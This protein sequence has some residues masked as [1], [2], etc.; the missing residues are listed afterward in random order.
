MTDT[1]SNQGDLC[2]LSSAEAIISQ[3]DPDSSWPV[4]YWIFC[5]TDLEPNGFHQT[6][7]RLGINAHEYKSD[8]LDRSQIA[9][10]FYYGVEG[11]DAN[12]KEDPDEAVHR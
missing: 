11:D 10:D 5:S 1:V 3:G 6:A 9:R 12:Q 7:N 2:R 4:L 8:L